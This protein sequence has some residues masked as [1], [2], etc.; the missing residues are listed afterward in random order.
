MR[1]PCT[2]RVSDTGR[3]EEVRINERDVD[4]VETKI[5]I[6]FG[7]LGSSAVLHVPS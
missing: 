5:N 2:L 4:H 3:E 1:L 7:L 6:A